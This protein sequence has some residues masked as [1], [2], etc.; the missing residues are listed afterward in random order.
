MTHTDPARHA[1]LVDRYIASWNEADA[2]ARRALIAE[3]FA[4]EARYVDPL[5]RGD[6]HAELDALIAGVQARFPGFGFVLTRP[7]ESVDDHVRFSWQLG[8]ADAPALI[9]GTD[10]ARVGK[11]GRFAEVRGFLDRVPQGA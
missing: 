10:V 3:T 5:M 7:V 6:G 8:P 1:A 11:D 9:E 4:T 2:A